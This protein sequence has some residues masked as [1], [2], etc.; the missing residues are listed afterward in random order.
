[1][2]TSLISAWKKNIFSNPFQAACENGDGPDVPDIPADIPADIPDSEPLP[3]LAVN[4]NRTVAAVAS[5]LLS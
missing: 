1:M 3:A 2:S 4:E 5:G